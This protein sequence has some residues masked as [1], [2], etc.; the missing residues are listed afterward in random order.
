[1]KINKFNSFKEAKKNHWRVSEEAKKNIISKEDVIEIFIEVFDMVDCYDIDEAFF[2]PNTTEWANNDWSDPDSKED[3]SYC[4]LGYDI[5]ISTS[6]SSGTKLKNLKNYSNIIQ[7]FVMA[8]NRFNEI[9]K[10]SHIEYELDGDI[11]LIIKP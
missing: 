7:E 11:R 9:Y 6:D 10:P 4:V 5:T 3:P 2:H 1:M 8:L